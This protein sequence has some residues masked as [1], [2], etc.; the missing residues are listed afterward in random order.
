MYLEM[1][2]QRSMSDM[3]PLEY[4]YLRSGL[5]QLKGKYSFDAGRF[6]ATSGQEA[7]PLLHE[8]DHLFIPEKME[9][10]WVSGQVRHPGLVPWVEGKD[11]DY[12]IRLREVMP[13]TGK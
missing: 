11:W 12:Y 9:M 2:M 13:I 10:V 8:G 3:T 1:L 7:N 6:A 5:L 4:S